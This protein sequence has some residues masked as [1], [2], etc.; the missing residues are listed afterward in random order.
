MDILPKLLGNQW[1]AIGKK[2]I[3]KKVSEKLAHVQGERR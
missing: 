2:K 3:K 1:S